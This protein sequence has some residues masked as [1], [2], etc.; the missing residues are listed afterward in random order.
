MRS[1]SLRVAVITTESRSISNRLWYAAEEYVGAI[2]II[3]AR[4]TSDLIPEN[5]VLLR[6][7]GPRSEKLTTRRLLGLNAVLASFRPDLVHINNELWAL[8]NFRQIRRGEPFVVHGAENIFLKNTVPERVK[9]CAAV[10]VLARSAGYASWNH[11][12]T[13]FAERHGPI[14][15]PTLTMPAIIPPPQFVPNT[16]T[17]DGGSR[18]AILLVG[19]LVRQKGFERVIQAIG[20]CP[21]PEAY[22]VHVC[23]DGPERSHLIDSAR[24]SGVT[25]EFHGGLE[26][27]PLADLMTRMDCLVQP[28]ASTPALVEQFG[29]A[30][31]E[32]M[33]IGLPCLVSSSG[34][35]PRVVADSSCVFPEWNIDALAA[36]LEK[37]RT[38]ELLLKMKSVQQRRA[39]EQ[40][41]PKAAGARIAEFWAECAAFSAFARSQD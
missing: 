25:V 30:V 39:A 23:G 16:W 36:M 4:D 2:K 14:G 15:L 6:P 12:G 18:F 7:F 17:G 8:S 19:R 32:A 24:A 1:K 21:R 29:R 38:D 37:L 9:R 10:H 35:L 28:S 31:A 26:A 40:W 20:K 3:G 5:Q 11:A 33:T 41:A 27:A 22:V 13:Y 34:E